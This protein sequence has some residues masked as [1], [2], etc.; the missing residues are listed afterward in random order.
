MQK[1]GDTL[2]NIRI[3]SRMSPSQ[4][5]AHS[6]IRLK[7]GVRPEWRGNLLSDDM[8]MFYLTRDRDGIFLWFAVGAPMQHG[9]K[10][11][12]KH[13]YAASK[14]RLPESWFRSIIGMYECRAYDAFDLFR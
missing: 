9:G 5:V 11:A 12:F 2:P 7:R 3:P 8:P 4:V 14:T 10:G 6:V 1:S 13:E